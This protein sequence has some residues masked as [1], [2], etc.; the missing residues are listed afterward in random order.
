[1]MSSPMR[2][3]TASNCPANPAL[4]SGQ[5]ICG[6]TEGLRNCGHM[7]DLFAPDDYEVFQ[8]FRPRANSYRQALGMWLIC[9]RKL[10]GQR[11][12]VIEFYGG[13]AWLATRRFSK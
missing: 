5:V 12:D 11:Y 3:L 8:F 7:V 4:G 10:R 2:V 9:S 1:M 6:Y 13:E